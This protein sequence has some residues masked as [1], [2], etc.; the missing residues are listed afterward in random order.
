MKQGIYSVG[1]LRALVEKRKEAVSLVRK[2]ESIV[3]SRDPDGHVRLGR[4]SGSMDFL[5]SDVI[6]RQGF[7]LPRFSK[8]EFVMPEEEPDD[9][10]LLRAE[11]LAGQ[12]S[13]YGGSGRRWNVFFA[14][15]HSR[16]MNA[17]LC[18][19]EERYL[20]MKKEDVETRLASAC[21]RQGFGHEGLMALSYLMLCRDFPSLYRGARAGL[22]VLCFAA[23]VVSCLLC[24]SWTGYVRWLCISIP[25][26]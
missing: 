5:T 11:A 2:L 8:F 14:S 26:W 13:E 10:Q 3:C 17:L 22:S 25:A 7:P 19:G 16:M 6:S 20:F 21:S 12:E 23:S 4:G 18:A 15:S 1:R 24:V 9:A